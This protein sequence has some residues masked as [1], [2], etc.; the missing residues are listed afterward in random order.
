MTNVRR[1]W[2]VLL[3]VATMS[4]AS[5][6]TV[7]ALPDICLK[8]SGGCVVTNFE[9]ACNFSGVPTC[10]TLCGQCD[11]DSTHAYKWNGNTE[12]M[13]HCGGS[14]PAEGCDI[15]VFRRERRCTCEVCKKDNQNCQ[16]HSECCGNF[17]NPETY[18]CG[19]G[20]PIAIN[21]ANASPNY[22]LT[23][24]EDG[25]FFDIFANGSLPKVAWTQP[26][27]H[28]AWLALDRDGNHA[29][30]NGSELFGNATRK[31][32][33]KLAANGFEALLDLDGG[34]EVSDGKIDGNDAAYS[35]L[36]LW[37]DRNHNGLAESDE[38]L[39][40]PQSGLVEILTSYR[41]S[42][43]RDEHGNEY[44][45]MGI[46]YFLHRNNLVLP[47]LISDVVLKTQ[48]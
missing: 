17:C 44:R 34:P 26:D 27:S 1:F 13:N 3:A 22:N 24:A 4:I 10:N 39:T 35:R 32:D 11:Q 18:Q 33:G 2:S 29:I 37:V 42:R 21:L 12:D 46:A 20:S 43:R 41:E 45:W 28:V 36:R 15:G 9:N 30:D 47:R 8:V 16:A 31:R 48:G 7:K 19:Q 40:L 5:E 6:V 23:S 38:L 14:G 25:V